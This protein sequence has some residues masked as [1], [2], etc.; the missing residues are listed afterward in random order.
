MYD[1]MYVWFLDVAQVQLAA[2]ELPGSMSSHA[3]Y[4]GSSGS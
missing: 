2:T 1:I 3:G 4:A